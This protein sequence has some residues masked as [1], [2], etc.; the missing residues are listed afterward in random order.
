MRTWD[1]V[2]R[3][4]RTGTS[5]KKRPGEVSLPLFCLFELCLPLLVVGGE[6]NIVYVSMLISVMLQPVSSCHSY[7]AGDIHP[8][9]E[10]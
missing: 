1:R 9:L 8:F 3:A 5:W 4:A 10:D 6:S 2:R 7:E